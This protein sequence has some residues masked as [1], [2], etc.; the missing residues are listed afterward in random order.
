MAKKFKKKFKLNKDELLHLR[1]LF[2]I[3]MSNNPQITASQA[4]ATLE[5][6]QLVEA[7]LWRRFAKFCTS[8]G[9]SLDDDAPDF[10]IVPVGLPQLEVFRSPSID[11]EDVGAY[12]KDCGRV[13]LEHE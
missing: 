2:S 10:I 1:D 4:L 5:G 6:R 12:D 11:V 7:K 8:A 3:S 13:E 9:I